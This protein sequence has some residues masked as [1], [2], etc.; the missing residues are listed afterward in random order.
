MA[1][2]RREGAPRRDDRWRTF[3]WHPALAWV[4]DR[5]TLARAQVDFLRRVHDGLRD[6]AFRQPA[7]LK[8][9]SLQL[10]GDEKRLS[11]LAKTALFG[12]GRLTLELLGCLPDRVPLAWANV[13]DGS[14]TLVVENAGLFNV[15]VS[16]LRQLPRRPYGI[17]V[18]GAGTGVEQALPGLRDLGRPVT[19]V[20]YVGDL[21]RPGLRI[22]NATARTARE[23]GLPSLEPAP[24]LHECMLDAAAHLGYPSGWLTRAGRSRADDAQLV[25]WLPRDVR[26]RVRGILAAGRRVPEEVLGPDELLSAWSR[27]K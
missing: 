11:A 20:N 18:Y 22:A 24:A 2:L 3:P 16:V 17:V 10:T 1:T 5:R 8:Y 26:A 7:P 21:D 19:S 25:S 27:V 23:A 4:A 9:R 15:A 14:A 13:G 12:L 6:G